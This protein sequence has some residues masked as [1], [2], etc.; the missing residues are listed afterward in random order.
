MEINLYPKCPR[1]RTYH[2]IENHDMIGT[3]SIDCKRCGENLIYSWSVED[4]QVRLI[5][6]TLEQYNV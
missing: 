3:A 1:C 4:G 5:V 6:N 2:R